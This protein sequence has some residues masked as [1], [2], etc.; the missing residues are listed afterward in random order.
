MKIQRG[1]KSPSLQILCMLAACFSHLMG[2]FLSLPAPSGR[3]IPAT[4]RLSDA[5]E[6]AKQTKRDAMTLEE[7]LPNAS[8]AEL[9]LQ[10]QFF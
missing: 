6:E 5:V 2:C 10:L 4:P 9:Q 3:K 7:W 1:T 8:V